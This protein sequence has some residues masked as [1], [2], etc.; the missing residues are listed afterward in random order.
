MGRKVW[1]SR[2]R[3]HVLQQIPVPVR[4]RA[5]IVVRADDS[6]ARVTQ[7]SAPYGI[8][9]QLTH[10]VQKRVSVLGW[11]G[12]PGVRHFED[13]PRL[14]CHAE[15]HRS[16]HRHRLQHLGGNHPSIGRAGAK[17]YQADI[18]ECRV[19]TRNAPRPCEI[20]GVIEEWRW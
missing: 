6:R 15:Y 20:D 11:N 9:P 5:S 18:G 4:E 7:L 17:E 12:N 8:R 13:L 3:R 2:G 16:V 19:L 1:G 14:A 10:A